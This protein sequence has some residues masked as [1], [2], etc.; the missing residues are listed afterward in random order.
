MSKSK[1]EKTIKFKKFD[2][3]GFFFCIYFFSL[4]FSFVG[5]H[6]SISS[7]CTQFDYLH[8]CRIFIYLLLFTSLT[9]RTHFIASSFPPRSVSHIFHIFISC[10]VSQINY[11][12]CFMRCHNS[13]SCMFFLFFFCFLF[14]EWILL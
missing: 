7:S 4:V 1:M 9:C 11:M 3:F 6:S 10:V 5:F 14:S 8:S 12:R 2:S 13:I